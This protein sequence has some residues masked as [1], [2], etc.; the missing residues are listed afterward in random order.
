MQP[1]DLRRED[2]AQLEAHGIP[3]AEALRQLDV[4]A[5]PPAPLRLER[6]CGLGDGIV[7]LDAGAQRGCLEAYAA[8]RAARRITKFVPASGAASRMFQALLAIQARTPIPALADLA[9]LPVTNDARDA[10]QFFRELHRFAFAGALRDAA[11]RNGFNLDADL[12]AGRIDRALTLLLDP[13]HLGYATLPKALI[14]FHAAPDGVRTAFDEHLVEA[15]G[16]AA[17]A[18]GTC[19]LHLTVSPAHLDALRQRLD[20]VRASYAARYGVCYA[21]GFSTQ[22]KSTDTLAVDLDNRPFRLADGTLLLRAGGHGALLENL[23]DLGGD[24]VFLK[25]ID[26]VVAEHLLPDTLHWK[27]VL[28]GHLCRVQSRLFACVEALRAGAATPVLQNAL[29]FAQDDLCLDLPDA[30]AAAPE[31]LRALLL[32][33]LDRPIRVCGM[34]R[35]TGEPGGG[36]FWVRERDGTLSLQV[37]ERAQIDASSAEQQRIFD[38]ATHFSPVDF[39]CGVR[40]SRG[41]AFDLP[42]FVDPSAVFIAQKSAEGRPLKAIERPGLWNGGMAGWIT[43][44]VEVPISTFNPVKTVLDLLRPAHQPRLTL[45]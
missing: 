5:H 43:L 32:R 13:T 38:A 39:V 9:R 2:I 4:F 41:Q 25:N 7:A 3:V 12:D 30:A 40:N 16:Y 31:S 8:A 22:K 45:P 20:A 6:A 17:Q 36:P 24:L 35:N 14:P 29:R 42:R 11:R 10:E 33:R 1:S 23:N 15:A 18:D 26:N 28:A 34:V 37:V 44:F 21:V 27:M 19:N